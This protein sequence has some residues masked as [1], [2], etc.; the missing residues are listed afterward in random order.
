MNKNSNSHWDDV[1]PQFSKT[2]CDNYF[3]LAI[4]Q[5][6]NHP[7]DRIDPI[8]SRSIVDSNM[9]SSNDNTLELDDINYDISEPI[10]PNFGAGDNN[11]NKIK[12]SCFGLKKNLKVDKRDF[13]DIYTKKYDKP[14]NLHKRTMPICFSTLNSGSK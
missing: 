2:Y 10:V 8:S 14:A 1:S 9:R 11:W 7:T 13:T 5:T 6:V 3:A 12:K 4:C